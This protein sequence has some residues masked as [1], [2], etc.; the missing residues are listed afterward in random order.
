MTTPLRRIGALDLGAVRV[1]VALSDE[2]GLLAH[3][4]GCLAAKPRAK[5]LEAL[6]DLVVAENVG[7]LIVGFPLDMLGTEGEAARRTRNLAQ[8]IA[9]ATN[10]EVVLFDERLSTE[11]AYTALLASEIVGVKAR[12]R[13]DEASATIILQA[14]LD[15]RAR[16]RRQR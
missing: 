12:A 7:K 4:H 9:N 8:A 5:L 3:P 6:S 13:I 15:A 16:Q 2:L 11:E 14:W 1:G 10:L